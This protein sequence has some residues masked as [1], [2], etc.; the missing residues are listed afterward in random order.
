MLNIALSVPILEHQSHL[1]GGVEVEDTKADA[2]IPSPSLSLV[3]LPLNPW[4]S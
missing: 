1:F 3:S 4:W 2:Q